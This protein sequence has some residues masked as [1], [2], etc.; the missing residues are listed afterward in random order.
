MHGKQNRFAR[1][2]SHLR[3][4][5]GF[6]SSSSMFA[7]TRK[8]RLYSNGVL[9]ELQWLLLTM[10]GFSCSVL[11]GR[12]PCF[13]AKGLFPTTTPIPTPDPSTLSDSQ[14][15]WCSSFT[16]AYKGSLLAVLLSYCLMMLPASRRARLFSTARPLSASPGL[17][18]NPPVIAQ[19]GH[20]K[21]HGVT[22]SSAVS[23]AC[24]GRRKPALPCDVVRRFG[25][26]RRQPLPPL[27]ATI[28]QK[29]TVRE[30]LTHKQLM[31]EAMSDPAASTQKLKTWAPTPT[32]PQFISAKT[33]DA[34]LDTTSTQLTYAT[35]PDSRMQEH[36]RRCFARCVSLPIEKIDLA[37][38]R[39]NG[40]SH[41]ILGGYPPLGN[42]GTLCTRAV[43]PRRCEKQDQQ[44]AYDHMDLLAVAVTFAGRCAVSQSPTRASNAYIL[45]SMLCNIALYRHPGREE[46]A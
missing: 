8:L 6:C 40:Q 39:L 27:P 19:A 14:L 25:S 41:K 33:T 22:M 12:A 15:S 3:F 42:G 32:P 10:L 23:I 5:H 26:F 31:P 44:P 2:R 18:T 30:P 13:T 28:T 45:C 4:L 21:V 29:T 43:T 7:S 1:M 20:A 9:R 38:D 46:R 37:I 11:C 36:M 35:H 24:T 17:Q 16:F 34:S